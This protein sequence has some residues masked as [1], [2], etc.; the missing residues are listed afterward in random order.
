M[1]AIMTPQLNS[2]EMISRTVT[3]SD[4]ND[5]KRVLEVRESIFE[6]SILMAMDVL[7]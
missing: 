7:L 5:G 4:K 6:G 2:H 3:E 1:E